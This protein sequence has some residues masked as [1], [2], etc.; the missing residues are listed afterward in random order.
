MNK[1]KQTAFQRTTGKCRKV[2]STGWSVIM[3]VQRIKR[4][5]R[6]NEWGNRFVNYGK[7]A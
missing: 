5:I 7:V 6:L 4:E 1:L 3:G 2:Q